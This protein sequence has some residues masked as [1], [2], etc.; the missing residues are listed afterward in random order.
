VI[1]ELRNAFCLGANLDWSWSNCFTL[2][3]S[4]P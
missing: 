4:C 3:T 2:L 1:V